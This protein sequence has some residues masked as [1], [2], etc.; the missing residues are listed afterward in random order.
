VVQ[1]STFWVEPP[2]QPTHIKKI[3]IASPVKITVNNAL[4]RIILWSSVVL[5]T[6]CLPYVILA[7][8]SIVKHFSTQI[9]GRIPL[10]III[11]L[12]AIY[13]TI[14]IKKKRAASCLIVLAVSALIVIFVMYFEANA[15]KYIHIPEYVL[16]SWILYHALALDYK[17]SG[18]LLLVFICAAMLGVLDEIM[19]G[20]HPQRTYGSTDM[21][22]DAASS[23]IGCLSLM[24][25][26]QPLKGNWTWCRDFRQFRG[27]LAVIFI[28]AVT[29]VP[30][31]SFLFEVRDQ[32]GFINGYPRW[33]LAG[34][35]LLV[36]AC[37][38]V[39][40]F[41]WRRRQHYGMPGP[42]IKPTAVAVHTTA[43]L[44]LICP[45]AILMSMHAL[46]LWVAVAGINFR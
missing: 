10:F 18:I 22:I 24:G 6:A 20:M 4:Q 11:A 1:D 7:Y 44:W 40:V 19:Q 35:S 12:A 3:M 38:A 45:L 29:A 21:I 31:C 37:F 43:I 9:A 39:I 36:A 28:G 15:N 2:P 16:M 14:C 25:L 5:Y 34:N 46:V 30:M 41:H 13:A 17:G 23:F 26:K 8:R 42:E 27:P 32:G 33:L